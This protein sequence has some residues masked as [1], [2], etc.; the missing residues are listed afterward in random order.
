[1]CFVAGTKVHTLH[2]LK[3]IEDIQRGD[4]VLTRDEHN[5][6]SDNRYRPVTELF[7][8]SPTRLLKIAYRNEV[9]GFEESLTC[10]GEHP[11]FVA[12][13]REDY[14]YSHSNV[15]NR[16]DENGVLTSAATA[17]VESLEGR[18]T[19][20]K[21]LS[22]GDTLVLADGQQGTVIKIDEQFAA[23]GE[24]FT[25]Y[26]FAVDGDHT[27]FVGKLGVWVHNTGNP[28]DE[29]F[30]KFAKLVADGKHYI[31]AYT[32]ALSHLLKFG[33]E[34]TAM[35]RKHAADLDNFITEGFKKALT[36]DY[37]KDLPDSLRNFVASRKWLEPDRRSQETRLPEDLRGRG[38]GIRTPKLESL[39]EEHH[40]LPDA[41]EFKQIFHSPHLGIDIEDFKVAIDAVTHRAAEVGLH[42]AAYR[43]AFGKD[44]N[45]HWREFLRNEGN[46][47]RPKIFAFANKLVKKFGLR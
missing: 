43:E 2:G 29:A 7:K 14:C 5:P 46:H 17:V 10:T 33:D 47:T 35:I 23:E 18:F 24:K 25:T 38:M 34:G 26:N 40:L 41:N 15:I 19:P 4:W 28:C 22:I 45:D 42:S 21:E 1:M 30:E 16:P 32:E 27:Y 13:C 6:S 36:N 37:G 9:T 12:S 20:A 31:E 44:W 3:N 11:F 8:T 39:L